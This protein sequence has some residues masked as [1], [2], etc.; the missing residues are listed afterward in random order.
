MTLELSAAAVYTLAQKWNDEWKG[1]YIQQLRSVN[2][3]IFI[4]KIRTKEKNVHALI[5]LP[6]TMIES[7][8][9]WENEDDQQPIV[10]ATKKIVDNERIVEVKQ[11]QGDRILEL[12]G[13]K[14]N[15]IIELFG[16]G[17]IIVTDNEDK[18]VFVHIAKEWKGRTLKMKQKYVPPQNTLV[19]KVSDNATEWKKNTLFELREDK[20]KTSIF[21]TNKKK[22][23]LLS[24]EELFSKLENQV[25]EKWNQPEIDTKTDAQK[26]ALE[27]NFMRQ[28]EQMKKW[29]DE[30]FE[31]QRKGE[32]VYEHYTEIQRVND[33]IIRAISQKVPEK[34]ILE[35][36]Q[37]KIS[38]VK[39]IDIEKGL[40]EWEMN[41]K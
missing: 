4:L 27:I 18:I 6:H 3:N 33:A 21:P 8:H 14:A 26:R 1:A 20:K 7:T 2:E 36:L 39:N 37:K 22:I 23:N 17:N 28:K 13:E 30:L 31:S 29:E 24:A 10:N 35:E 9:K 38:R 25:L 41:E 16:G 5:A 12:R 40:V 19:T 15:I 11:L 34:K 32:W